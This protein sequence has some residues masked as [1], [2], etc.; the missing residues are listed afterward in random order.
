MFASVSLLTSASS[1]F[2]LLP[3]FLHSRTFGT[4]LGGKLAYL[5]SLPPVP[6]PIGG[7]DGGDS[8]RAQPRIATAASAAAVAPAAQAYPVQSVSREVSWRLSI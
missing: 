4:L 2:F 6:G 8:A 7:G 5:S 3:S 1:F